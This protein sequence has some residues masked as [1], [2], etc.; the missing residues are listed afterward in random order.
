[1]ITELHW[2]RSGGSWLHLLHHSSLSI[3]GNAFFAPKLLAAPEQALNN[4]DVQPRPVFCLQ[5]PSCSPV[6]EVNFADGAG[7]SEGEANKT[8]Q[9]KKIQP[10]AGENS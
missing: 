6:E 9:L 3:L 10:T 1:M 8:S 4:P 5:P 2:R 7:F